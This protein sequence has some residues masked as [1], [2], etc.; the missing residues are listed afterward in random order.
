MTVKQSDK[1]LN[2]AINK[3]GCLF[4]SLLDIASDLI[5]EDLLPQEIMRAYDYTVPKHMEAD[6]YVKD[7]AEI[8]RAGMYLLGQRFGL[9]H[10]GY[11]CDGDQVL[12]GKKSECNYFISAMDCITFTHFVR[13]DPQG[14]IL[15]NPGKSTGK[16]VSLRGYCVKTVEG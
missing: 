12:W 14:L 7:H 3:E 16:L 8:I 5:G 2:H 10:Y 6:C 9:A 15:Y 13:T 1:A 11:R 4:M